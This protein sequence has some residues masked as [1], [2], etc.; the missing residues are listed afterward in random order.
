MLSMNRLFLL[1][2]LFFSLRS[3]GQKLYFVYLQTEGGQPFFVKMNEKI[4]SSSASGY[5]ILSRL[6][7]SSYRFNIGFPQNQ[8]PEQQFTVSINRRDHGFILKNFGDKGWGLFNLKDLSVQMGTPLSTGGTK[9]NSGETA[10]VSAFTAI[11]SQA[12]D[13]PSLKEKPALLVEEKKTEQPVVVEVANKE[14]VKKTELP[15]PAEVVKKAD[16]KKTDSPAIVEAI[17]KEEPKKTG[18][19]V[20]VNKAGKA[21]TII[22]HSET[23]LTEGHA[24][25]FIEESADGQKD[26]IEVL[27]PEPKILAVIDEDP[28]KDEPAKEKPKIEEPKKEEPK[29]EEA[30]QEEIKTTIPPKEEPRKEDVRFI[31][32]NVKTPPARK[33]NCRSVATESDFL[34]LRKKMAAE[35]DD[36]DMVDE[37]RKYFRTT[38]FTTLQVKNLGFLFLDDLGKYKFFDVAYL[39][40]SDIENFHQL[41]AELKNEYYINRF[42]TML[43]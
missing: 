12:A 33:N 31:E 35:T 20:T 41:E 34:K 24:I 42:R 21:S 40:V 2:V 43:K 36:D 28:K 22:R 32:Q 10:N 39:F 3:E 37:A 9:S 8:F 19:D 11:L 23:S 25:V 38:C 7:D 13:D 30:K 27:I 16:N 5:I 18:A 29:K 14:E 15:P 26:T 4:H 6:R 17:K 1:L